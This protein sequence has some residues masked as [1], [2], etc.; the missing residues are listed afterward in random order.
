MFSAS[1]SNI[2]NIKSFVSYLAVTR[3]AY[4]FMQLKHQYIQ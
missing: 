1:Y 4:V 3:L 2:L